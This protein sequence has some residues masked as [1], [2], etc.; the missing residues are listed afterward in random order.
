MAQPA[1]AM[2]AS[3]HPALALMAR[4]ARVREGAVSRT[5]GGNELA[6]GQW[7]LRGDAFLLRADGG[8]GLYYR[9]GEG[10]TLARPRDADPRDLELWRNGTLYAAIAA[11]NGL[12]PLHASAVAH[13]GQVYAFT[14][15]AGAGK[16]TLVAAL[17]ARGFA[18]FCDDTL[19]LDPSEHGA[20]LCLPGHKRLKLWREGAEL[21][22]VNAGE[23]VASDYAKHFVEPVA[24]AMTEPLP[25]AELIFLAAGSP[26]AI[27]PIEGGERIARLDDDHYTAHLWRLANELTRSARFAALA[28][29]ARRV[30]MRRLV[31]PFDRARF[32]EG[33]AC[34]AAHL[35]AMGQ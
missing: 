10:V 25:L 16:S 31:R 14:G 1:L 27:D 18:Q 17:S 22:G 15:P 8:I 32:G 26:A 35:E 28:A 30:P 7:E 34:I 24:G 2:P 29:L 20:P 4:E 3:P 19:I 6:D 11:L 9:R 13:E 23:Q 12:Y 21:A 5:L 33:V